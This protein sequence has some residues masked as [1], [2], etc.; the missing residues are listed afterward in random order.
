MGARTQE[1]IANSISDQV[2]GGVTQNS[3]W[4]TQWKASLRAD[5]AAS[6]G[7]V[8][9]RLLSILVAAMEF[10][11]NHPAYAGIDDSYT[12]ATADVEGV[13]WFQSHTERN[14]QC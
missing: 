14:E 12:E 1:P 8:S 6:T 2:Q 13:S 10:A 5:S 7:F 9:F 3:C 4:T 11:M